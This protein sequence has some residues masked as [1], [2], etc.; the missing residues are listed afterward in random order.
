MTSLNGD[1]IV[2]DRLAVVGASALSRV[3]G[4]TYRGIPVYWSLFKRYQ[5]GMHGGRWS[6]TNRS[7]SK[8]R[9]RLVREM[10][11][12]ARAYFKKPWHL[13]HQRMGGTCLFQ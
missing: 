13:A 7:S 11:A 4:W 12:P 5:D 1:D 8:T 10:P 2:V 3:I 6:S 9:R